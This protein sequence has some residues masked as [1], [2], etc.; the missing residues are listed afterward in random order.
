MASQETMGVFNQRY[1]GNQ[2]FNAVDK[3]I[4]LSCDSC[5]NDEK[6]IRSNHYS[7]KPKLVKEE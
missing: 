2:K 3:K 5:A 6:G 4:N 1:A 7:Q